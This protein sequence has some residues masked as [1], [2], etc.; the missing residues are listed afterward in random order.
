ML[1]LVLYAVYHLA[2]N[3]GQFMFDFSGQSKW[4]RAQLEVRQAMLDSWHTYEKYGW[5]YDVYHPI[6]QE[7]EIMG[8]KTVGVDDCGF[9]RYFD[10]YGL[11]RRSQSS[12]RL[13]QE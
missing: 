13:D 9:I 11:S 6:K 12:Q 10:D 2:S 7:G 8:P 5:G 3:G 1:S 4:E